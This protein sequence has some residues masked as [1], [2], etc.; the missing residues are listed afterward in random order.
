MMNFLVQGFNILF[1]PAKIEAQKLKAQKIDELANE[2]YQNFLKEKAEILARP[3]ADHRV[4]KLE[5]ETEVWYI[6]YATQI[7]KKFIDRGEKSSSKQPAP[8][9]KIIYS[10]KQG[11]E[12][13][14]QQY[15]NFFAVHDLYVIGDL[16]NMPKEKIDENLHPYDQGYLA[17]MLKEQGLGGELDVKEMFRKQAAQTLADQEKQAKEAAIQAKK[18]EHEDF[19][20]TWKTRSFKKSGLHHQ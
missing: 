18:K 5:Y 20:N 9:G 8:M 7:G 6:D 14:L 1:N 17:K 12:I 15:Q 19:L 2:K 4:M 3:L 10:G 16:L 11:Y 13:N